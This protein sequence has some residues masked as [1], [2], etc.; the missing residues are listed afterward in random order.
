MVV[1]KNTAE[2]SQYLSRLFFFACLCAIV[3]S[4]DELAYDDDVDEVI[5]FPEESSPACVLTFSLV[6]AFFI[7]LFG[8][9]VC[10][11][12]FME[13]A[14]MHHYIKEGELIKGDV[15][16]AEFARGGGQVGG[17]S[18]QRTIAEY[19]CFIEYTR[20]LAKNYEVRVRKQMRAKETD[21]VRPL[22]PKS[23]AM[24]KSLKDQ[25]QGNNLVQGDDT[26]DSIDEYVDIEPTH[27]S[28]TLGRPDTIELY[29]LSDFPTSALPR[30][31]VERSCSYR[32]RLA[33]FALIVVVLGLA[34]FC[35]RIAAEALF[36]LRDAGQERVDLFAVLLLVALVAVHVPLVHYGLRDWFWNILLEE[37]MESGEFVPMQ[38]DDSSLSTSASD[39]FLT[40]SPCA[41]SSVGLDLSTH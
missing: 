2:Q 19:I 23:S 4:E 29:V 11:L 15:M 34:A 13:D 17:C 10:Y 20:Q 38:R 1:A 22:F 26:E 35:T 21:F 7:A 39:I 9:V 8:A 5:N 31:Q 24:L 36:D 28:S 37:Y 18:N 27:Q 32:H 6:F 16:S 33:T 40:T 14:L 12:S 30:R 25:A 41:S 3:A